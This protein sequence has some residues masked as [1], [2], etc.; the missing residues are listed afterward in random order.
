MEGS[1]LG[2]CTQGNAPSGWPGGPRPPLQNPGPIRYQDDTLFAAS[3]KRAGVKGSISVVC[4]LRCLSVAPQPSR[5]AHQGLECPTPCSEAAVSRPLR[6]SVAVYSRI[7]APSP[8]IW[9]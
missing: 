1:N 8:W 2:T 5:Q 3:Q 7:T 9:Y 4:G 6:F